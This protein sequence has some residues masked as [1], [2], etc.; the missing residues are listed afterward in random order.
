MEDIV[1][2]GNDDVRVKQYKNNWVLGLMSKGVIVKLGVSRWRATTPLRIED[3]GLKFKDEDGFSFMNKYVSL[4]REKLLPPEI[5]GEIEAIEN[6]ARQKLKEY[7]F[8]TVWGHFVPYTAFEKWEYENSQ[9]KSDFLEAARK[10]GERY[11]EIVQT[12]KDEYRKMSKDVWNRLYPNQGEPTESF[13]E[14]FS[15]RIVSKIPKRNDL[16]ASFKYDVTYFV[17]PM[18]S[19]IEEDISKVEKIKQER[20]MVKFEN[21]I[22]KDTKRKVA[23]E[24][25][26][27]KQEL[28]DSFLEATVVSMRKYVAELCESVLESVCKANAQKDITVSQKRKIQKMIKKIELLNFH[29]DNE[30]KNLLNELNDE[31]EK[32]KGARDKSIVIQKLQQIV[33]VGKAEFVPNDFNPSIDSLEV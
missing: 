13:M 8:D 29:N 23:E 28:I 6:S 30:I 11:D 3:L 32:F 33:E 12:V 27:R 4:G 14:D 15:S 25:F 7:C 2:I 1:K 31:V 16:V 24:Y 20:E 22:E 26:K 5:I 18:P 9:V 17:I 19:I 10:L 21:E